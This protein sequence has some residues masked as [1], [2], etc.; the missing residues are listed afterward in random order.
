MFLQV[1][2]EHCD[3]MSVAMQAH[4]ATGARASSVPWE[5]THH[6]GAWL[7][8]GMSMKEQFRPKKHK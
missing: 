7:T 8:S 2:Q 5:Q 1:S 6:M 4:T 3:M